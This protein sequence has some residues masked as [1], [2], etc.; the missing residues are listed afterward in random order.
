[1]AKSASQGEME[2]AWEHLKLTFAQGSGILPSGPGP[3]VTGAKAIYDALSKGEKVGETA[4]RELTPIATQ[5]IQKI[6]LGIEKRQEG[7][8]GYPVV[9]GSGEYLYDT[10]PTHFFLGPMFRPQSEADKQARSNLASINEQVESKKKRHLAELIADGKMDKARSL[11]EKW[12][13]MPSAAMISDH[14]LAKRLPREQRAKYMKREQK[15]RL[16]EIQD[17]EEKAEE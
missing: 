7:Q 2:E 8:E 17:L 15:L 3:A 5:R 9:S 4:Y 12:K 11:A 10:D 14:M 16:K 13:L 6:L 1:M